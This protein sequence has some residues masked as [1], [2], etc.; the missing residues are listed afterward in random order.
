MKNEEQNM[1][2]ENQSEQNEKQNKQNEDL[3]SQIDELIK[4]GLYPQVLS[5]IN[6]ELK[7]KLSEANQYADFVESKAIHHQSMVRIEEYREKCTFLS[8]QLAGIKSEIHY[9]LYNYENL[10]RNKINLMNYEDIK[11]KT[12][13][14]IQEKYSQLKELEEKLEILVQ[15][16]RR[17]R[18]MCCMAPDG[19]GSP[20]SL[21]H[22]GE[23][24]DPT[25]EGMSGKNGAS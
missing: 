9:M 21:N 5:S 3:G 25:D 1:K 14:Q 18:E 22:I 10:I 13:D 24:P 20:H 12:I 2:N 6:K 19:G 11:A 23:L 16:D 15:L 7:E 17:D 4:L 8:T